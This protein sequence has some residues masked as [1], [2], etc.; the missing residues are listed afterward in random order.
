MFVIMIAAGGF[1]HRRCPSS[2]T[3]ISLKVSLPTIVLHYDVPC[4]DNVKMFEK[5]VE[6]WQ[7]HLGLTPWFLKM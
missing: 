5:L 3:A 4:A 2:Q 1:A 6:R 7:A